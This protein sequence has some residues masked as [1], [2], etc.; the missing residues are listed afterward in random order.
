MV[1]ERVFEEQYTLAGE[2]GNGAYGSVFLATHV[3][4]GVPCA[5]K[6]MDKAHLDS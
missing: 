4:T 6:T 5:V 1:T 3:K 2:L